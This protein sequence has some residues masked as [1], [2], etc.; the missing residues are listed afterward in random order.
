[1]TTQSFLIGPIP[2]GLR[3]DVKPFAIPENSWET[4]ENAYQ[5]RGRIIKRPGY[6]LLGNLSNGTPVMGLRTR[7]LFALNL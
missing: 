4:L 3:K 7:E 2:D 6:T 5:W 1:M